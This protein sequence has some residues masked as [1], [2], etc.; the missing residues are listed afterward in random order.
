MKGANEIYTEFLLSAITEDEIIDWASECLK[1]DPYIGND[2]K[3]IALAGLRTADDEPSP[4]TL[5]KQIVEKYY[6]DFRFPSFETETYAKNLLRE[7]C[8]EFLA[9]HSDDPTELLF[10][11]KRIARVFNNPIWL[12]RLCNWFNHCQTLSY[13]TILMP[14]IRQEIEFRLQEL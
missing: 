3:L 8:V 5:L 9:G 6:A 4:R 14:S 1:S 7:R 2:R 12:G 11:S 10:L 13:W